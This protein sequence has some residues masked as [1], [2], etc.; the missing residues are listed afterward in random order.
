M[1]HVLL[2]PVMETFEH[3]FAI[4]L[5]EYSCAVLWAFFGISFLWE[6]WKLTFSSNCEITLP[7]FYLI[8]WGKGTSEEIHCVFR[9]QLI[10]SFQ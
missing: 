3:Y 7:H 8:I 9:A 1:V 5:N 4:V 2:K 6:E 10:I